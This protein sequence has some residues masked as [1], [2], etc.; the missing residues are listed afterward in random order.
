EARPVY[1]P[2]DSEYDS[3]SLHDALPICHAGKDGA[4][5]R[6]QLVGPV[7][8]PPDGQVEVGGPGHGRGVPAHRL[9]PAVDIAVQ[10]SGADLMAAVPGVPDGHRLHLLAVEHL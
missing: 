2:S 9:V 1:H 4:A 10:A 8:V 6:L 5:L 3:P 7:P